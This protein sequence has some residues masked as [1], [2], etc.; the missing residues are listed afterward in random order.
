MPTN[1]E[2]SENLVEKRFLPKFTYKKQLVT[3]TELWT[4]RIYQ[5]VPNP[6]LTLLFFSPYILFIKVSQ[7]YR[8]FVMK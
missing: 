7:R 8:Y 5:M 2:T 6:D 3:T 1:P 4:G